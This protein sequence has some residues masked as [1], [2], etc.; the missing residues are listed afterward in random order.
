MNPNIALTTADL[1]PGKFIIAIVGDRSRYQKSH[2]RFLFD[3]H[4]QI[5]SNRYI[6]QRRPDLLFKS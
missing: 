6:E 1:M 5:R 2:T 4:N 3:W